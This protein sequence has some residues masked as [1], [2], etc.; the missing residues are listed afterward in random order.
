M[1]IDLRRRAAMLATS[2]A[3]LPSAWAAT[4][5][6]DAP[7]LPLPARPVVLPPLHEQRLANGL[8]LIAAPRR[9]VPLV[10]AV[11]LLR[12]GAEADPAGRAGLAA[13][14]A[15]LLTKGARRGGRTVGAAEI[16]R[17]AEALG[18]T[19]DSG[20]SWRQAS[21]GMTVTS[22]RLGEALSLMADSTLAPT[23]AAGEFERA[24][25]Q[26][27][28]GLRVS[29]DSPGELGAMVARRVF[30]GDTTFGQVTTL[31]S[32]GRMTAADVGDFHGGWY[33]PADAALVLAGDIDEAQAWKWAQRLFGSWASPP[34]A[35]RAVPAAAALS[36]NQRSV[37]VELPGSGQSSVLLALPFVATGAPERRVAQVANMALGG[38]YSARL[39]QEIRIRRGLSYSVSSDT[40]SHPV[41]GMLLA[42]AQTGHPNAVQVLQV[43]REEVAKLAQVE[44]PADELAARQATLI[45]SFGRR[46]ETAQGLA[47][48]VAGQW[49]QGRPLAELASYVEQVQAVTP[50]QVRDFAQR[51][52][53]VDGQRG[54]IVGDLK[55]TGAALESV[56]GPVQRLDAARLD[57]ERAGLEVVK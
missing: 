44:L 5:G 41:G 9:G 49:V 16:A 19:L 29:L 42:Q 27:L 48:L 14:T 56:Q 32:L 46:V 39:N 55:A 51:T 20:S 33:R 11:L 8:T 17:Q 57:L 31:A 40:E 26:A 24:R 23:L 13:M 1:T 10:H 35:R 50:A 28:D 45:G 52:W 25:T 4:P 38:G 22:P 3:A 6:L 15:A 12:V 54:V 37:L 43:M 53:A 21:I 18:G 36:A 30:W 2:A 34:G 7:P 47:T